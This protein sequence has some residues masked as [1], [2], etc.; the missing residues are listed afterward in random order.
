M[1]EVELEFRWWLALGMPDGGLVEEGS[2]GW[3]DGVGE[4]S[5]DIA[6]ILSIPP[7]LAKSGLLATG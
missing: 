3:E 1:V 4:D 5:I 2:T 7:F 6:C